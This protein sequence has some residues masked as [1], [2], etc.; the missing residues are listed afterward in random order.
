MRNWIDTDTDYWKAL[1][2]AA[3]NLR[4]L[5][6]SELV[7]RRGPGPASRLLAKHPQ[8]MKG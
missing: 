4:D 8:T 6:A 3:L 5:Y 1:E 2:N 7:M